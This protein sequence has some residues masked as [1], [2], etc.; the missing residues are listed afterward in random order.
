MHARK[1]L[2]EKLMT[3]I[4]RLLISAYLT[5]IGASL[6]VEYSLAEGLGMLQGKPITIDEVKGLPP[7][8]KLVLIEKPGIHAMKDGLV[9]DIL[10]RPEYQMAKNNPHFHHYCW[11]LISKNRYF[12]ATTDSERAFRLSDIHG[13]AEYII[14]NIKKEG[15]EWPYFHAL[16]TEEAEAYFLNK[17]Y[18]RAL[19]KVNEALKLLPDYE[20]A[21]VIKSDI[22]YSMGDKNK[23][24][25]AALEGITLHPTSK[26]L[27]NRLKRLSYKIPDKNEQSGNVQMKES[28]HQQPTPQES[29]KTKDLAGYSKSAVNSEYNTPAE[30]ANI[31][32]TVTNEKNKN[33]T[34]NSKEEEQKTN[35]YCRFCP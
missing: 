32:S 26:M 25:S 18:V 13:N 5:V 19:F 14:T 7:V 35:P 33:Q 23:S 16:Y 27:R 17:D 29:L 3:K 4:H 2:R 12:K 24:L 34:S 1:L 22:Y 11:G 28:S 10:N 15:R 21:Y 9:P 30:S 20:K 6:T 31:T 8:C